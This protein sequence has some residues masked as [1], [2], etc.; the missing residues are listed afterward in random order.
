MDE[1]VEQFLIESREL[2]ELAS[3]DLLAL[4]ENPGDTDHLESAFRA[5][6]T[7]KGSAAIVDFDAMVSTTHAVEDLLARVR[8]G[9][10]SVSRELVSEC[11]AFLNILSG[12]LDAMAVDGQVPQSASADA[13]AFLANF[14]QRGA[15]GEAVA[16]S[17]TEV[18]GPARALL[19]A[20]LDLLREQAGAP[21]GYVLSAGAVAANVLFALGLASEAAAIR[22]LAGE[23]GASG[24]AQALGQAIATALGASQEAVAKESSARVL[25][26]DVGRVDDIVRLTGELTIAK[27]AV[28]HAARLAR[29]ESDPKLVA[30]MLR[31]QHA[32]LDRLIGELQRSVLSIRVLPLR[33]VFQRFPRLIRDTAE[34]LGKAVKVE[35]TG[36]D[37]EADKVIVENLFEPLLHTLRN[38][39][40][41]GIES[42]DE[43]A[44]TG[45]PAV[46]T[47]R[48]SAMRS[49]DQVIVEVADDGRG[50]DLQNVRLI[51]LERGLVEETALADMGDEGILNLIFAPGFSTAKTVSDLSGRGV[52]M[53]AV[54]SS[55]E[56]LG[57]TV[58]VQTVL[59][60]GTKVTLRLPFSILMTRVMTVR[61]GD[62]TFG[63][64]FENIIETARVARENISAVGA[65]RAFVLRD[66]TV[67]VIDLGAN[68]GAGFTSAG[69]PEAKLVVVSLA[70]RL[71]SVEVDAL[72][73]RLDVMLR[74]PEG[75][76]AGIP[77]ISGTSLLGD[78]SV[79]IVLDL[80]ELVQ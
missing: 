63:I 42:S 62:Q 31:D 32:T 65:A 80:E 10:V 20:Q 76:L 50:I 8:R 74:P 15:T 69:G 78:G 40:D 19:A 68:L 52:G 18:M 45:K 13:E 70:G 36:E 7:L 72:G 43:R 66:R 39:L 46:A 23:A 21:T 38:A 5:F 16:P 59:D 55:V 49:G 28:G 58:R 35:I 71:A 61:V 27:N 64:P 3:A 75:L 29:D 44:A 25:R 26:V 11:L 47:L 48:L 9:Q 4:E 73:E 34:T 41:H 54:R 77:G 79:L 2:V 14:G 22:Q 57:G 12:W 30:A 37:T 1:F 24:N 17:V 51:A 67:P 33:F 53:N 56:K 6:H 60:Q